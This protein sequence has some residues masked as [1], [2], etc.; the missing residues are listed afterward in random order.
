MLPLAVRMMFTVSMMLGIGYSSILRTE[1]SMAAMRW[2]IRLYWNGGMGGLPSVENVGR[3]ERCHEF[4]AEIVGFQ[5]ML[6]GFESGLDLQIVLPDVFGI[7]KLV[8]NL[9]VW[10]HGGCK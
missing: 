10:E 9:E 5:V 2:Y 4:M 7:A 1:N 3:A 6:N 8:D